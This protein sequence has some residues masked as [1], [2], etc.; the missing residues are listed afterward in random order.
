MKTGT[1]KLLVMVGVTTLLLAA[2]GPIASFI[3]NGNPKNAQA[4]IFLA[5]A[6]DKD[7]DDDC[8]EDTCGSIIDDDFDVEAIEAAEEKAAEEAAETAAAKKAAKKAAKQKALDE[9]AAKEAEEKAALEE[10][11]KKAVEKAVQLEAAEAAAKE[12][13]TEMARKAAEKAAAEEEA[14]KAVEA[15]AAEASARAEAARKAAEE[16]AVQV[17]ATKKAAEEAAQAAAKEAE[18]EAARAAQLAEE[19]ARLKAEAE[20]AAAAA[21][22]KAA[23]EAARAAQLAEIAAREAAE[24][25]RQQELA[26]VVR[27]TPAF[28]EIIPVAQVSAPQFADVNG[29]GIRDDIDQ[30][31]DPDIDITKPDEQI[32]QVVA[33]LE[34]KKAE[35]IKSGVLKKEADE[36]VKKE[37]KKEKAIIKRKRIREIAKK[38]EGIKIDNS[39][40][41]T[42]DDG[43]S[44]EVKILFGVKLKKKAK[45]KEDYNPFEEEKLFRVDPKKKTTMGVAP[46]AKLSANGFTILVACPKNKLV[47]LT[48]KNAKGKDF[49]I[50]TKKCSENSKAIFS[51]NGSIN[52]SR[53]GRTAAI[54]ADQQI[55]EPGYY[56]FQVKPA[57]VAA[58]AFLPG[59]L[60]ASVV[61]E[62]ETQETSDAV[63]VEVVPSTDIPQP[64]VKSIEGVDIAGLRN[65]QVTAGED[66]KI[67]VSGTADISSVVIGTFESA[68]FTS[69]MLADAEG[70]LFEVVS[71]KPLSVGDHEVTIY[72]TRPEENSQ[73]ESVKLKFSLIQTAN[74]ASKE[75]V[76]NNGAASRASAET[77]NKFPVIPAAAGAG[78]VLAVI[79]GVL[80][81]RKKK[82]T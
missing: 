3:D 38:K 34:I 57:D 24:V 31:A 14:K 15:N 46:G 41:S 68:V 60:L 27:Q 82:V 50:G 58:S 79:I 19:E 65:I 64:T 54:L 43:V 4:N 13:E 12:A 72:S 26:Q 44:D 28:K 37:E 47:K 35:L 69:A 70:G 33:K 10:A 55:L 78:V 5:Q 36:I 16:E 22:L 53:A 76:V 40:Q 39:K 51:T 9:A 49:V 80:L 23:E 8:T 6:Q 21:A 11:E 18:A 29:N 66:G 2:T 77:Q 20:A 63:L 42:A 81:T 74:A 56:A 7:D 61:G 73:S 1:K 71:S 75:V 25:K 48:A 30:E 59:D 52:S 67:R 45:E 17:E 32:V 62:P